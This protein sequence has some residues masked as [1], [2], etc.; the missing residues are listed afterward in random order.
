[1]GRRLPRQEA[2]Q[3]GIVRH[4]D[5]ALV[6]RE[7]RAEI[8]GEGARVIERAGMDEEA[9][10]RPGEGAGDGLVH[11]EAA[12]PLP[13]EPGTRPRKASSTS[14]SDRK[15]S[16]SRPTSARAV[17]QGIGLDLGIAEDLGELVVGH[18]GPAEPE[19]WLAHHPEQPPVA[20]EVRIDA[21]ERPTLRH[22]S[23]SR[24]GRSRI[25]R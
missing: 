25:S 5:R 4:L 1:M 19:P 15:S 13:D 18:H 16:S 6:G 11:E 24:D 20:R 10:D 21:L 22:R 17:V 8:E 14:P 23:G 7:A 9:P 3:A 2:E 12:G